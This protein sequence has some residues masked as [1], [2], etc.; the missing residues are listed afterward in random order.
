MDKQRVEKLDERRRQ[1][2]LVFNKVLICFAGAVVYEMIAIFLQRFF[3]NYNQM[4]IEAIRFAMAIGNVLGLLRFVAP[5]LMI[6]PS[7]SAIS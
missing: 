5:V 6:V 3:V 2:D 1:E 4:S 7:I